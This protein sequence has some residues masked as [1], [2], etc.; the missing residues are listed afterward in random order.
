MYDRFAAWFASATA[1]FGS[2]CVSVSLSGMTIAGKSVSDADDHG[3][4]QPEPQD[5]R[6]EAK[7]TE[8]EK[9]DDCEHE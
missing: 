8:D 4:D 3:E 7:A 5:V 9:Q 2:F 6:D 1:T